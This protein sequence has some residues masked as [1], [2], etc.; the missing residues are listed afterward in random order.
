MT[1][2]RSVKRRHVDLLLVASAVCRQESIDAA[3]CVG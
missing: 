2:H 3:I 1:S